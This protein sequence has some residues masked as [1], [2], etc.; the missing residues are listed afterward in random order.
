MFAKKKSLVKIFFLSRNRSSAKNRYKFSQEE[1]EVQPRIDISLAKKK[2]K[3]C[4]EK[5]KR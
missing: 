5:K 3:F 1:I 4:Q 2:Y